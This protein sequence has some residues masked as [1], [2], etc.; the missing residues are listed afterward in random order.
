MDADLARNLVLA[1]PLALVGLAAT[2]RTLTDGATE[3][4]ARVP[5]A[6]LATLW[7]WLVVHAVEA[8]TS[9]WSFTD[10]PA[11]MLGVPVEVSLGWALLWGHFRCWPVDRSRSGSSGSP[12]STSS[13]WSSQGSW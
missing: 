13:R 7:V 9:W 12:G 10:A 5:P 2:L 1:W 6:F 4:M 3:L 8:S 11:S